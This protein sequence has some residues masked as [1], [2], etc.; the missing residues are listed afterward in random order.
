MTMSRAAALNAVIAAK[1]DS[2]FRGNDHVTGMTM[3]RA[4]ALNAVIAAKMASRFRGND[5][6]GD[7]RPE[8]CHSR[9][10]ANP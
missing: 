2:R 3:S 6:V 4:G 10:G 5:D 7:G 1:V 8:Y 9:E